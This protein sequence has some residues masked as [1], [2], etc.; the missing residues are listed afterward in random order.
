[1]RFLLVVLL[2]VVGH[3][4]AQI[5]ADSSAV[6]LSRTLIE[7]MYNWEFAVAD[8]NLRILAQKY[9]NHPAIPFA[10]GM[11]LFWKYYP[12]SD[13]SSELREQM[14]LFERS[15]E[16][17]DQILKINPKN[18]EVKYIRLVARSMILR[19]YAEF[20]HYLLALGEARSLYN[21]ILEGMKLQSEFADFYLTSGIYYYYREFYPQA[22]PVY[23][24]FMSFFKKGNCELGLKLVAKATQTG[25]F[26]QPEA[27]SFDAH[28]RLRFEKDKQGGYHLYTQLSQ[29]YPNN[30]FFLISFGEAAVINQ[31][32]QDVESVCQK[33][34]SKLPLH[35]IYE[36]YLH[37]FEAYLAELKNDFNAAER[38]FL[39]ALQLMPQMGKPLYQ[40]DTFIYAGLS[41]VYNHKLE[42]E[43]AL[44]YAK[45]A[46]NSDALGII[47]DFGLL[48]RVE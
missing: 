42:K 38:E 14:E 31:N 30:L 23:R 48:K 17:A 34:K 20:G 41:R 6:S 37:I 22:Y 7:Q 35:P 28:I 15:T 8:S 2:F 44:Y 39:A 9:P 18:A 33:L 1:M 32:W 4:G 13:K 27:L 3:V 5:N 12:T 26:S 45:K 46:K 47:Q 19:Y 40:H 43:K 36:G 16:L 11:I 25:V 24:P 10:S 29:R 21:S